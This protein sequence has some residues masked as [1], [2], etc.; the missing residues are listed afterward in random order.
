[1][2][3]AVKAR[4]IFLD[5]D[6]TL[7]NDDKRISDRDLAAIKK[8]QSRGLLCGIVTSRRRRKIFDLCNGFSPDFIAYYDGAIAEIREKNRFETLYCSE[9][10]HDTC[11]DLC[12]Y[13]IQNKIGQKCSG[14]AVD[15]MDDSGIILSLTPEAYLNKFS[16][17]KAGVLR[18][19]LYEADGDLSVDYSRLFEGIRIITENN[20]ILIGSSEIN[21]GYAVSR[22]LEYFRTDAKAS[23]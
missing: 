20:D 2:V 23:I 3:Q 7:L 16:D 14:I 11:I 8:C 19:R 1:M 10:M 15:V 13:F 4:I 6:G 12:N 17:N 21:K 22:I 5:L 18:F 9:I